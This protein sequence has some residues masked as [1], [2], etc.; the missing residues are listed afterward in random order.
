MYYYKAKTM[1]THFSLDSIKQKIKMEILLSFFQKTD[2]AELKE[3][4]NAIAEKEF[5][6][7]NVLSHFTEKGINSEHVLLQTPHGDLNTRANSSSVYDLAI[8]EIATALNAKVVHSTNTS[9]IENNQTSD[10]INTINYIKLTQKD[11][12]ADH[13]FDSK[14]LENSLAKEFHVVVAED[15]TLLPRPIQN[16]LTNA[17]DNKLNV[18]ATINDKGMNEMLPELRARMRVLKPVELYPEE[19]SQINQSLAQKIGNFRPQTDASIKDTA[20]ISKKNI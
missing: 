10:K 15:L 18:H 8:K 5:G 3:Q 2:N 16:W 17:C 20:Q 7:P 14:K 1:H 11:Y 4:L 13:H 6:Q 19:T 9:S 12:Y